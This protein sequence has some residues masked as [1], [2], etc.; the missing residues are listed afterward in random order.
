MTL[1]NNGVISNQEKEAIAETVHE[2][3]KQFRDEIKDK[4]QNSGYA[5][6]TDILEGVCFYYAALGAEVCTEFYQQ[7]FNDSVYSYTLQAGGFALR[8]YKDKTQNLKWFKYNGDIYSN[9]NE[10]H[11]WI[12]GSVSLKDSK[13]NFDIIDFT[14]RHYKA[15][16]DKKAELSWERE[17]LENRNFIW[18]NNYFLCEYSC[19]DKQ[20]YIF[21]NV[22]VFAEESLVFC[23]REDTKNFVL[24]QWEKDSLRKKMMDK[25]KE[26]LSYKLAHL[27]N[28]A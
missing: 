16:V 14:A 24:N 26:I 20:E 27:E 9:T 11:C 18:N 15:Q 4:Y 13:K 3:L 22:P 17:D 6:D 5:D 7:L 21:E 8:P 25:S 12:E 28:Q 1:S 10:Y 2:T 23:G 19:G